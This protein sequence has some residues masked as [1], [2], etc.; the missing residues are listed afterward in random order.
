[1]RIFKKGADIFLNGGE[2]AGECCHK[3]KEKNDDESGVEENKV[4]AGSK[5]EKTDNITES[6]G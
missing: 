3:G 5:G 6:V 1:M 2:N 4:V